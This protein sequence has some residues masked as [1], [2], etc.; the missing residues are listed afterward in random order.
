MIGSIQRFYRLLP[1]RHALPAM[2]LVVSVSTTPDPT[3][4]GTGYGGVLPMP[5][6]PA[7]A[8]PVRVD[9]LLAQQRRDSR[10]ARGRVLYAPGRAPEIAPAKNARTGPCPNQR[11]VQGRTPNTAPSS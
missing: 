3:R 1:K 11:I 9:P 8:T 5:S 10:A 7:P 2:L 4:R 6:S